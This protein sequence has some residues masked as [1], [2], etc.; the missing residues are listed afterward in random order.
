[1][2]LRGPT[3]PQGPPG[4]PGNNITKGVPGA[5]GQPGG[6]GE[7][8]PPGEPGP[9][10]EKVHRP[11]LNERKGVNSYLDSVMGITTGIKI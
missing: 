5:R 11:S 8:G 2:G 3:G 10:G 4:P 7:P 1:M 9:K 6:D